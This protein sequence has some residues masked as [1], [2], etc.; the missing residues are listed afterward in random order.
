MLLNKESNEILKK[1]EGFYLRPIK[2][3]GMPEKISLL[4]LIYTYLYNK[5]FDLVYMKIKIGEKNF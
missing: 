5:T 3:N 2:L 1:G 4:T